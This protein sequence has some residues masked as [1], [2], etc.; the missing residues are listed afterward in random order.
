[1]RRAALASGLVVCV[2]GVL[3]FLCLKKDLVAQSAGAELVIYTGE[4][5]TGQGFRATETLLDMPKGV[6]D[7]PAELRYG[8]N[9][10]VKSLI[11]YQ[12]TWRLCMHGRL[13]TK[14]DETPIAE[15]TAAAAKG[16]GTAAGWSCLVSA[17]SKGPV[18]FPVASNGVWESNISSIELVSEENL[19][20][21]AVPS[22]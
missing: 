7:G 10:N 14:I 21:W 19:P 17:N 8:W 1:M 22:Q 11:V 18:Q 3:G 6:D 16:K 20:D 4:N 5:F 2:V 15:L 13:N 12:G 9:D